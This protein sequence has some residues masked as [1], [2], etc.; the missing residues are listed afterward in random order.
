MLI[1]QYPRL[2]VSHG[3]GDFPYDAIAEAVVLDAATLFELAD[4]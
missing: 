3:A 2:E 1:E 4:G